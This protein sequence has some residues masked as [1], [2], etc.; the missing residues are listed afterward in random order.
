MRLRPPDPRHEKECHQLASDVD[1]LLREL[2]AASGSPLPDRDFK[3]QQVKLKLAPLK[4]RV[5]KLKQCL[6]EHLRLLEEQRLR[7]RT[8]LE[9][10]YLAAAGAEHL[11]DLWLME[12][13]L[14]RLASPTEKK[15][16]LVGDYTYAL[17]SARSSEF[18]ESA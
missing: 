8:D 4:A 17:P 13:L 3:Q 14:D 1:T 7:D 5:S 6:H 2:V 15:S 16:Q 11:A 9:A 10:R 18:G 12:S